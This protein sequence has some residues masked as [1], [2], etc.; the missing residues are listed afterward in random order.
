MRILVHIS[1]AMQIDARNV[2]H[3]NDQIFPQQFDG[4][5]GVGKPDFIL[6]LA[7]NQDT[8]QGLVVQADNVVNNCGHKR[9]LLSAVGERFLGAV[10]QPCNNFVNL[11]LLKLRGIFAV[12]QDVL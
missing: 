9:A 3:S 11:H 8:A 10:L 1:D 12:L 4:F 5:N 7:C 2:A 6:H